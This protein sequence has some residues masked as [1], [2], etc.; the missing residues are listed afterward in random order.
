MLKVK[1]ESVPAKSTGVG[2][3]FLLQ[4]VTQLCPTLCNPTDCSPPGSSVHGL[5]QERILEWVA[6]PSSRGLSQV[7]DRTCLSYVSC[8][9]RQVLYH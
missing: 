1:S 3:H 5:L 9:G 4:L 6:L 2:C 8:I 7:R